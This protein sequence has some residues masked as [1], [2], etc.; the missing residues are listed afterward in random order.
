MRKS[1]GKTNNRVAPRRFSD[2]LAHNIGARSGFDVPRLLLDIIDT[3][4]GAVHSALSTDPITLMDLMRLL[5][6]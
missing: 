2:H 5:S 6:K 4:Q 1:R 3:V